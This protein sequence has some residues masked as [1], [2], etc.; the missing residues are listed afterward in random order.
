ADAA[1]SHSAASVRTAEDD[2]GRRQSIFPDT[3][4]AGEL[5]GPDRQRRNG[6]VYARI[7][8]ARDDCA[9]RR[10][11]RIELGSY[12]GQSLERAGLRLDAGL[13]VGLQTGAR[14]AAST[15]GL[16]RTRGRAGAT[17]RSDLSPA[18]PDVPRRKQNG[19][20]GCAVSRRHW[21]P[22]A[23]RRVPPTGRG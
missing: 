3:G 14:S 21:R 12:G 19:D 6:S 17:R 11:R 7:S 18:L 5:E 16:R 9:A 2:A 22:A 15:G 4:G 8:Q 10:A 23:G 13:A 1:V 20:G